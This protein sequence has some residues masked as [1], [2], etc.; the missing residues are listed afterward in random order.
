MIKLYIFNLEEFLYLADRCSGPVN[1][2]SEGGKSV[3]IRNSCSVQR[4]CIKSTERMGDVYT[5][6]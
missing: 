5:L 2:L 4:I 3:D 6:A 1:L